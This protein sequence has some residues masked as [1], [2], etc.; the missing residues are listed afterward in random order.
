MCVNLRSLGASSRE[1]VALGGQE[2]TILD[3]ASLLVRDL[4]DTAP[5]VV[6]DILESHG[7]RGFGRDPRGVVTTDEP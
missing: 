2:F 4:L 5:E 7:E 6:G 3:A 1:V